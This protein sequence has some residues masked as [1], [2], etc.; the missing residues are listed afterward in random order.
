VIPGRELRR[1]GHAVT[2]VFFRDL[3][4]RPMDGRSWRGRVLIF[5][6]VFADFSRY[7]HLVR[8]RGGK[9]VVDLCDNVFAFPED[10]LERFYRGLWPQA[11][12]V[13][14]ASQWLGSAVVGNVPQSAPL[15][16]IP[17]PVEGARMS[18]AFAPQPG[19]VR[20]LWFGYPN[21]LPLLYLAWPHLETLAVRYRVQLS[22]V[23]DWSNVPREAFEGQGERLQVR[24]VNWSQSAMQEELQHCDLVFIPSDDSPARRTKSANRVIAALWGGRYVVASPLPSYQPFCDFAGIGSHLASEV[25]WA[26]DHADQIPGRI[27]AG[28]DFIWR[29]YHPG[30]IAD[31]WE[32]ILRR[33]V[34]GA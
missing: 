15:H 1:R 19:A 21:N 20:L 3:I 33:L 7:A 27:Q 28:Q 30:A 5:G 26:L 25:Q 4:G 10:Q 2:Q 23:T 12:A 13:T 6:K 9:V 18:P 22:I 31:A 24:Q 17:D 8:D 16:V 14:V 34:D 32:A 11:D 29:H